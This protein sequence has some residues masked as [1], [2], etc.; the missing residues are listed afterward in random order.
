[1]A[2]DRLRFDFSHPRPVTQD[3]L[4]TI[5]RRV[6]QAIWDDH[7]VR[8]QIIARDEALRRG[9]M[10]LFGEKYGEEVRIVEIPGV[11]LELCGGT[12]LRHT[13]EAGLFVILGESGVASGVR[14][15][16]AVTGPGAFHHLRRKEEQLEDVAT[17]LR[18][19]PTN[20]RKRTLELLDERSQL[21]E[22]LEEI[23]QGGAAGGEDV[24]HEVR[25]PGPSALGLTSDEVVT[26]RAVRMKVKDADD[27][28][29]FGDAV[30]EEAVRTVAVV[31]AEQVDGKRT[32]FVFVTDDLISRGIR[33][34]DMVREL[35][36]KVG[37]RGGGRPH[38][39]QGGIEEPEHLDA[40]L[41][42]GEQ[43]LVQALEA[44]VG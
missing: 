40:A 15:I 5:E 24:V 26:Y 4:E 31:A 20:L 2:P 38:M 8:W 30:R 9:A 25:I 42:S 39:A 19:T 32:L 33:A 6:N 44:S 22:L 21:E 10:A 35:A 3:E 13:G 34:G 28:R 36:A 37:G 23:R 43:L 29:R 12:H 27:A 17:L 18:T 41:A 16:E 7:P 11:S 1:V 14:R